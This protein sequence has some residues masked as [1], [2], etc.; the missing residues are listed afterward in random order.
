MDYERACQI[1]DIYKTPR[2][3]QLEVLE[4]YV[5]GTCYDDRP[6]FFNPGSDLPLL[7]RKPCVVYPISEIAIGSHVDMVLG[8]GS[9]PRIKVSESSG[10]AEAQQETLE[11]LIQSIVDQAEL[12]S[13]LAE[14]LEI[15]MGARS[16]AIVGCIDHGELGVQM[17]ATKGCTLTRDWLGEP[18]KL[19][20]TYPYVEEFQDP[21]DR[22]WKW[23]PMI[24]RRVI[25]RT[26]DTVFLPVEAT[27]SGLAK[28]TQED[29]AQTRTHNLGFCPVVW[30][31]FRPRLG[32]KRAGP[33]GR[34]LHERL[35]DEIDVLNIGLSQRTRSAHYA[36]DPQ[37]WEAGVEQSEQ[38]A[39]GAT[40]TPG[41]IVDHTGKVIFGRP[42]APHRSGRK[43]GPGVVW[44]YENPE[45]KVGMLTLPGDAFDAVNTHCRDILAILCEGMYYVRLEPDKAR[46]GTDV[47]GRALEIL[48]KPQV[49]YDCKIREDF[50]PHGICA[51]VCMLLR[52]AL[53]AETQRPGSVYLDGLKEAR[54]ILEGFNQT[55]EKPTA[56]AEAQAES[57]KV[58][59]PAKLD[60]EWGPMF[61]DTA[62][63]VKAK[64]EAATAAR[65][66]KLIS[67]K[68]GVA[69][70]APMFGVIDVEQEVDD[71][72][73]EAEDDH[74]ELEGAIDA[75]Q[76]SVGV[77]KNGA[78]QS[79]ADDA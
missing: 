76:K 30:Y 26:K 68:T 15:A 37:L 23:R 49:L 58:W 24:Y 6:D 4:K 73:E 21:T 55:I 64:T 7:A 11:A 38:I 51:A 16:V 25:D 74:G 39:P 10:I 79:Q 13:Q 35:L 47:S 34:A 32:R 67:K 36:G 71:L 31:S 53:A 12:K 54:S 27:E 61:P 33:D 63:D 50:G 78:K 60:L 66:G 28:P 1:A 72:E 70:V 77:K 75:L 52:V 9:W 3:R 43:K 5:D 46:M 14:A 29:P 62:A 65:D 57:V 2:Y 19:E 44:K 18:E 17:L 59:M 20:E 41:S 22:K 69:A 40:L 45:A 56:T 8:E 48:H 42:Y